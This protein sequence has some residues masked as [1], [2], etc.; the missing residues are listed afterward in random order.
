MTTP[1]ACSLD[2]SA[3]A[4]RIH[5]IAELNSKTLRAHERDGRV[6]R[7]TYAPASSARVRDLV[8]HE[9]ECC[10]FLTFTI[11]E[12]DAD[13]RL[14]VQAPD[15]STGELDALCA[16]FLAGTSALTAAASGQPGGGR[17]PGAAATSAAVVALA[18]GVCCVV[19]FALPAVAL[20]ATGGVLAAFAGGYRWML[21]LAIALAAAGWAWLGYQTAR[22][23]GRPSAASLRGALVTSALVGVALSWPM[24]ER[25]IRTAISSGAPSTQSGN[26]A[27]LPTHV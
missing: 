8:A 2:R 3:Y 5:R 18:C 1:I 6:L 17:V 21:V 23:R 11:E 26:L 14:T 16:P 25:R 15:V 4:E 10:A 7:L 22:S 24:L 13:V 9:S 27:S 19:P 12:R 20:T